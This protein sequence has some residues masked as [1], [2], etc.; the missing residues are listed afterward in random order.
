MKESYDL[1]FQEGK[2]L[3]VVE[4]KRH[5]GLVSEGD[6][7]QLLPLRKQKAL[8]R[9]VDRFLGERGLLPETVRLDLAVVHPKKL[10]LINY[11]KD[12]VGL[13]EI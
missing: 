12:V 6:I 4:V 2:S 11:C 1:V 8:K 9:G 10:E 5:S 13:A 3:V 7:F